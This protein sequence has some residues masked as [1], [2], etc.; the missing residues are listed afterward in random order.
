MYM[1][2][3]NLKISNTGQQT[4]TQLQSATNRNTHNKQKTVSKQDKGVAWF[5]IIV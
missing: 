4:A 5:Q 3:F 1:Y 2:S